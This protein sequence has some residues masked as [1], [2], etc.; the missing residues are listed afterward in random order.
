ME[1]H[2]LGFFVL[3]PG[4]LLLGQPDV[5][6]MKRRAAGG[7]HVE[8]D[9]DDSRGD[10]D[11]IDADILPYPVVGHIVILRG[12]AVIRYLRARSSASR[13]SAEPTPRTC[14]WRYWSA[15]SPA[16]GCF[17]DKRRARR[18]TPAACRS[19]PSPADSTPPRRQCRK[20]RSVLP[21]A[22]RSFAVLDWR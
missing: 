18:S 5:V 12:A 14:S 6:D 15:R 17:A 2:A 11:V 16:G 1:K 4:K 10:E 22:T 9:V 7:V 8:A 20:Q 13:C 21:D 19:K 3:K